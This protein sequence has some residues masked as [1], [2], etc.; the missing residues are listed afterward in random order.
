MKIFT[1]ILSAVVVIAVLVVGHLYWGYKTDPSR[2]KPDSVAVK[3]EKA[4]AEP[5]TG[6]KRS[7]NKADQ[8]ETSL[9]AYT[10]NWPKKARADFKTALSKERAYKIAIVGSD[11]M[12]ANTHGWGPQ[13]KQALQD[14]YGSYVSVSLFAYHLNSDE[15]IREGK[16]KDVAHFKPDLILFEPFILINNGAVAMDN[17]L[18]DIKTAAAAWD[19]AVLMIQPSYPLYKAANYPAQVKELASYAKK[20]GY[21]YLDHWKN[22]PDPD[23]DAFK[24]YVTFQNGEQT[25]PSNKGTKAWYDY[26]R[27]FF[28][29]E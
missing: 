16:Y 28:I 24:S 26:L 12:G 7:V 9:V 21:T 29:A 5:A 6:K 23:S 14:A 4:K 11:A 17:Q 15:F 20:E 10:K 27:K 2:F 3:A 8:P 25:A 22:W 18:D 19:D 13:L 1:A